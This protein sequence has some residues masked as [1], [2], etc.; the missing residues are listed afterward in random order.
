M[1]TILPIEHIV[2]DPEIRSGKPHIKGTGIRVQDVAMYY[3]GG[4]SIETIVD[5]LTLTLGQVTAALSYYFDHKE[6]IDQT[7]RDADAK[8]QAY[9]EKHG[10]G[11]TID[12][13][14]RRMEAR[15]ANQS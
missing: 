3:N 13:Y 8:V 14:K 15:K 4:W 12:E 7:M 6:E 1:D 11:V 9:I 5:Q 2:S 10:G